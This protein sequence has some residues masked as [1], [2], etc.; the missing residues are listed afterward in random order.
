MREKIGCV[1]LA[2]GL[3]TRMDGV[4]KGRQ[5]V[6]GVTILERVITTVRPQVHEMILNAN[7]D[8]DRYS[9]LGL[10]LIKDNISGYPGPLA[11]VLAALDWYAAHRPDIQTVLSVPT[12]TPLLPADLVGRL[13]AEKQRENAE[14]V[15]ARSGGFDHLVVTLWPVARRE[16]LRKALVDEGVRKLKQWAMR[17]PHARV[18]WSDVPQDPFV[19]VNSFDDLQQVNEYVGSN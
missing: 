17:Y 10:Q 2:G 15:W 4:D 6:D 1:L 11:G 7:G 19:N 14:I 9:D 3:A 12:D 13:L 5:K 8:I 18:E 16:E